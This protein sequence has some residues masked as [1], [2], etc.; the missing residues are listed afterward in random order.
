MG[1]LHIVTYLTAAT[2]EL[3]SMNT[4]KTSSALLVAEFK[5]RVCITGCR[6]DLEQSQMP[7]QKCCVGAVEKIKKCR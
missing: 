5:T 1:V 3:S 7:F 2:S 4:I 6:L